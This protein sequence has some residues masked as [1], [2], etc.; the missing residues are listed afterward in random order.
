MN[1]E[2]TLVS[3][4]FNKATEHTEYTYIVMKRIKDSSSRKQYVVRRIEEDRITY[5]LEWDE[6]FIRDNVIRARYPVFR[7]NQ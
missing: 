4:D 2:G 5:C 7:S 1:Y 6:R 3:L